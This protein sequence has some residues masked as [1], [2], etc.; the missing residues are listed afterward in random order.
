MR[1]T[2]RVLPTVNKSCRHTSRDGFTLVELLVV[3]AIIGILVALLLPAVQAA[4]EAARRTQCV[5]NLKQLGL[6]CLNYLDANK[7]FPVEQWNGNLVNGMGHWPR[8][9]PFIEEQ[10]L[11]DRIRFDR[12]ITCP[13]H[14]FLRKAEIPTLFCP[15]ETAERL[16][17][18][19]CFPTGGCND[20]T[21]TAPS[22]AL[23]SGYYP[24]AV[25]S[26]VGSYG[27]SYNNGGTEDPYGGAGAKQLYGCGGCYDGTANSTAC[28]APGEGYGGGKYHRGMFDYKGS[29]PPVRMKNVTDGTSKTILFGHTTAISNFCDLTWSAAT[30][31]AFGTSLPINFVLDQCIKAG[32][33][34]DNVFCGISG[35]PYLT[36]WRARGWSSFHSGGVPVC[37]VDGSV[38]FITSEIDPFVHNALGSR[39]G[40]EIV[41]GKF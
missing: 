9:L 10:S 30:G 24:G 37:F 19:R 15:S 21:D 28:P 3:I 13:S 7:V 17:P 36:S 2:F 39:A 26:Y 40:G 41:E 16:V 14:A 33:S 11:F 34:D 22:D 1:K 32:G 29:S 5:N 8:M 27:D 38:T 35:N 20:A 6:G 18:S 12:L 31:S 23:P 25:C 4:R